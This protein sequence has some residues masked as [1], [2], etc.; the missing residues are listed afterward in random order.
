[1]LCPL[2]KRFTVVHFQIYEATTQTPLKGPMTFQVTA[3]DLV[4]SSLTARDNLKARHTVLHCPERKLTKAQIEY[5]KVHQQDVVDR[6]IEGDRVF[7]A[8]PY[9]MCDPHP[10][11]NDN[12]DIRIN[13]VPCAV[14][15]PR[16]YGKAV[17]VEKLE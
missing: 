5:W 8:I 15:E 16:R 4:H 2:C 3:A 13:V 12:S 1:M 6:T 10:S 9:S 14:C 17:I 11:Y 7:G